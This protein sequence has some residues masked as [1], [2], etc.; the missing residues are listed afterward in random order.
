MGHTFSANS[1]PCTP[2]PSVTRPITMAANNRNIDNTNHN[3]GFHAEQHG[4]I[5]PP[6]WAQQRL[7]DLARQARDGGAVS[8]LTVQGIENLESR[9]RNMLIHDRDQTLIPLVNNAGAAPDHFPRC[10]L[11]FQALGN[12]EVEDLLQFYD[13]TIVKGGDNHAARRRCLF[14]F[15]GIAA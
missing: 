6:L 12:Q 8:N 13:L 11:A 3:N 2:F 7:D 10:R 1:F 14:Q 4:G 9:C 5:S 15:V